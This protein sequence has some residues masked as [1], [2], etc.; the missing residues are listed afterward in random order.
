M[1]SVSVSVD[2]AAG[3]R[4]RLAVIYGSET[5]NAE[6]VAESV[7]L[8]ARARGWACAAVPMDAYEV[9]RLP[10]EPHCVVAV[11]STTGQG[12]VP[13]PMRRMWRFLLRSDL[14]VGTSLAGVRTAVFGLGDSGYADY[15]VAARRLAARLQQLGATPLVPLGLGDDQHRL[16]YEGALEVWAKGLWVALAS[17]PGAPPPV[18]P[19]AL[20]AAGLGAPRWKVSVARGGVPR[21]AAVMAADAGERALV[22]VRNVRLTATEWTQDVR[23]VELKAAEGPPW[24]YACGDVLCI[25]PENPRAEVDAVLDALGLREDDAV[26]VD[27]AEG[28]PAERARQRW[29]SAAGSVRARELLTRHVDLWRSPRRRFFAVLAHYALGQDEEE[30][31]RLAYLASAEG[32]DA[33]YAYNQR[34]RRTVRE[35]L[36]DFPAAAAGLR[37]AG[38]A[39]LGHVLSALGALQPRKFS[40]SS[41]PA[42]DAGVLAVTVAVLVVTTPYKRERTGLCSAWLAG[43]EAG[44]IVS[45][46]WIEE[47]ALRLPDGG[48]AGGVPPPLVL[49]GP[50]TGLAPFRSM[51]REVAALPP[52]R[53]AAQVLLFFGCRHSDK[54]W[55]YGEE[56]GRLQAEEG[57]LSVHN[58]FSRDGPR[59]RYVQHCMAEQAAAVWAAL[60]SAGGCIMVSGSAK[61]MPRDVEDAVRAIAQSEGGRSEAEARAWVKELKQ[62]G[63]YVT[64]TWS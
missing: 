17:L 29:G 22:V 27:A 52:E 38:D 49:V 61:D 57:W 23:H 8:G 55:L 13:G 48:L 9:T 15:N 33:L 64:E 28:E 40:L 6:E 32:M 60:E 41:S 62:Q 30:H 51:V 36:S 42:S 34:E 45:R 7:A 18:D 24:A 10:E 21:A 47:G 35:V 20:A 59:K 12:E 26:T 25:R 5:G 58:A 39:G 31:E 4:P 63:R 37:A 1:A 11:C 56:M 2:T 54:D 53:R 19:A 50:G 44:D 14:P 46:A 43:L 16:G 3:G